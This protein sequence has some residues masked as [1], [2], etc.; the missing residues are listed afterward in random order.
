MNCVAQLALNVVDRDQSM[1]E[2]T[3]SPRIDRSTGQLFVSPRFDETVIAG[4]VDRG[5]Q[6]R[7][8]DE[9]NLLGEYSSPASVKRDGD[10]VFTGGVDPYYF[11]AT[12]VGVD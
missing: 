11:P 2:A 5:H 6:V 1:Q 4:L 10:G 9:R 8:K 3:N 7:I 12:A